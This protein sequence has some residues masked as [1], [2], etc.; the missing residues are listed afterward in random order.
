ME[1]LLW[2]MGNLAEKGKKSVFRRRKMGYEK[3]T[4]SLVELME[5][6]LRDVPKAMK[7]N[8]TA[9]Q[10]IRTRTVELSKISKEWRRLSLL[11]EKKKEVAKQ[12]R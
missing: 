4:D 3:A 7:G 10:R 6:V 12:G 1:D 8:K 5:E 11:Q 9:A 2:I